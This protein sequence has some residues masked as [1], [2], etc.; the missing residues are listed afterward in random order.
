MRDDPNF[1]FMAKLLDEYGIRSTNE[2]ISDI[3]TLITSN[4]RKFIEF[5]ITSIQNA[6]MVLQKYEKLN[7][8]EKQKRNILN[9]VLYR[10]EYRKNKLNVKC[11]FVVEKN[12]NNRI[13]N[14]CAFSE[15]DDKS[16]GKYTYKD[17]IERA[18]RIYLKWKVKYN[19]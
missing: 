6:D 12:N 1:L 13:I 18:I 5:F 2:F 11:I 7:L 8:N 15:K 14:L 3:S 17:N 9:N 10:L 4:K 16:K 19:E